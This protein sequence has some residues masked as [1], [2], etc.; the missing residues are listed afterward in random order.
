MTGFVMGGIVKLPAQVW[1]C[2]N[3][4]CITIDKLQVFEVLQISN[5]HIAGTLVNEECV[6]H[7]VEQ[8]FAESLLPQLLH[9][10]P[11][12]LIVG[13]LLPQKTLLE[14]DL[15]VVKLCMPT[16]CISH[17]LPCVPHMLHHHMNNLGPCHTLMGQKHTINGKMQQTGHIIKCNCD[18]PTL[19]MEARCHCVPPLWK[20]R[21]HPVVN[22]DVAGILHP[23]KT[24]GS[25]TITPPP[26]YHHSS[27]LVIMYR[28][29][30]Y[31][32]VYTF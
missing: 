14:N 5:I 32:V 23:L 4:P 7:Q 17:L 13:L 15:K 3:S 12:I 30:L 1:T 20:L 18:L 28:L 21:T 16:F 26:C 22:L 2:S 25:H 6:T 10:N 11:I 24:G 27:V 8:I 29:Y 9:Q 19:K 31:H